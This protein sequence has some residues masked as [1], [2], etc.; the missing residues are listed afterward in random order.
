MPRMTGFALPNI[1]E[2]GAAVPAVKPG[3]TLPVEVARIG[4]SHSPI[5]RG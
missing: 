3:Q 1:E 2:T 5:V 4:R